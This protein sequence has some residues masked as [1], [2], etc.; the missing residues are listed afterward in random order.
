MEN[1]NNNNNTNTELNTAIADNDINI[2]VDV[3]DNDNNF[4][5]VYEFM[6]DISMTAL[7]YRT[8]DMYE[9]K[10]TFIDDKQRQSVIKNMRN[11]FNF[12]NSIGNIDYAFANIDFDETSKKYIVQWCV[13]ALP[14]NNNVTLAEARLFILNNLIGLYD[15]Y[16][17]DPI[18]SFEYEDGIVEKIYWNFGL[19]LIH[20]S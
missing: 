1:I 10:P 2:D 12:D 19:N 7:I 20:I 16:M 4:V 18:Y 9:I 8:Y 3:S 15:K 11:D 14:N 6:S 17:K 13:Y 5:H